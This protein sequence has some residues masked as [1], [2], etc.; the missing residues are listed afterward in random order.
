MKVESHD[1]TVERRILIAMATDPL[2]LARLAPRW[3]GPQGPLASLWSNRIGSWC[4]KHFDKFGDAPRAGLRSYFE[5]WAGR[6][7]VPEEVDVVERF[8]IGLSDQLEQEPEIGS[9]QQTQEALEYIN[10]IKVRRLNQDNEADLAAGNIN[11]ALERIATFAKEELG[12]DASEDLFMDE[13]E[14]AS[15]F[16]AAEETLIKLDGGAGKFFQNELARDSF[17]ALQAPEKTGKT[18][19]LMEVGLQAMLQRKRVAFFEVGDMSRRQIKRRFMVRVAEQPLRSPTGQWP[20]LIRVP[21]S[22]D[23]PQKG[24]ATAQVKHT[25]LEFA[26]PLNHKLAWEACKKVMRDRVKSKRSYFK[27]CVYP[28]SSINVAGIRA[29]L[30]AWQLAGWSPDV[31]VIDYADILAPPAGRMEPRDAINETWKQLRRLSQEHHC[32]V[33]TATQADADSYAR[34]IQDRRNFSEDKRKLSHVTGLIGINVTAKEKEQGLMRLNWIVARE[35]DFSI[36]RCC[37]VATSLG[38]AN[39]LALSVF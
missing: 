12:E 5:K 31:V 24:Q 28:N 22:L 33:L 21:V 6:H 19:L 7:R 11:Q 34:D 1:G 14:V 38:L 23:K 20:C 3:Q 35:I 10:L 26:A 18:F 13:E 25:K 30:R 9:D 4:V 29:K 17:V 8:L 36:R 15:T 39:P 27:L 16:D 2:V 32:L 37:H